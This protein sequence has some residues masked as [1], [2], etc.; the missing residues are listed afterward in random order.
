MD[1]EDLISFDKL[2]VPQYV[3]V[4]FLVGVAA[5]VLVGLGMIVTGG[6]GVPFGLAV[7]VAGPVLTR[8]GCELLVLAFK[9]VD[10]VAEIKVAIAKQQ[11]ELTTEQPPAH[12]REDSPSSSPTEASSSDA[13]APPPNSRTKE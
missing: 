6:A 2:I 5:S 3:R 1:P 8:V 11:E 10:W 13:A 9:L 4:L 12:R 7:L